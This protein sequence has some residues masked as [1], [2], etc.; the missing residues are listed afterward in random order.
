M[1]RSS[2]IGLIGNTPVVDIS[3]LSPNLRVR[4]LVKLEG[5]NPFGSSKDRVDK[6]MLEEVWRNFRT[7]HH[8]A[9]RFSCSMSEYLSQAGQAAAPVGKKPSHPTPGTPR[10]PSAL[11]N[12]PPGARLAT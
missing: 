10:P 6:S 4:L 5:Q 8:S 9:I 11:S 2:S 7:P 12:S 3:S 1:I